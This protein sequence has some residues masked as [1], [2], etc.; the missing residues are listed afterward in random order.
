MSA[1]GLSRRDFIGGLGGIVVLFSLRGEAQG[2][3]E[4]RLPGSLQTNRRLDAWIRIDA[5]GIATVFTG[6]VELG[7][8]ILTALSQIVAE[9]LDLPLGRITLVSGDTERTPNEGTTS[10]SVSIENGGKALR[11]AGA[12]V[13]ALLVE[14]ASD[15]LGKPAADL[16]V[17]DGVIAGPDGRSVTYGELAASVNLQREATAGIA[18][19]SPRDHTLVGQSIG[20]VDIP[21]KVKGDAI[22]IQDMRL[23]GMLHGRIVRPPARGARLEG[24]EAS[25][26]RQAAGLV[27]IVRDGNFL[28]LVADDE[29][30]AVQLRAQL[31]ESAHWSEGDAL[32]KAQDIYDYLRSAPRQTAVVS[33]RGAPLPDGAVR[34]QA[35]YRKPYIAHASIGPSCAIA[36][37]EDQQLTVWTHSQNVFLLRLSLARVFELDIENVRCMHV[38]GSGCYG[39]NGADDVALDAALLARA[40][41]GRPVRLQWMRDDEFRWESYSPAMSM[42]IQGAV[43]EGRIVDWTYEVWSNT[44]S[45]RPMDRPGVNLQAAWDLESPVEPVAV[46]ISR[47]AAGTGDRNAVPLYDFPRQRVTHHLVEAMPLRTSALRTLGAH[48]NVWAIESFVDELAGMANADPVAFRLA[49]LEEVRG[50]AVIEA[51]RDKAG[52]QASTRR[53]G[54]VDGRMRGRGIGFAQYKNMQAYVAVVADL[55]VDARSGEIQLERMFAAADAGLA[56]NPDGLV[57]QIEGGMLQGAS[58]T[59][60]ESVQFD[61]RGIRSHDW[62]TYPILTMQEAPPI[63]V[64]LINRRDEEALGAGEASCGPA[65]AAIANAFANA[66]GARLRELPMTPERV[67]AALAAS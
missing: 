62:V 54:Q 13:R 41:P 48:A 25:G 57:N 18:P 4:R 32:P 2:V 39:H 61:E 44:H 14:L 24:Y 46:Q 12:E 67:R 50:R 11:Y 37:F 20:R 51:V 10:S 63:E 1:Q 21:P 47:G 65:A 52:W 64:Q 9:E 33:E 58:W 40:V 27:H 26:L 35:S 59:L 53:A 43:H 31:A 29:Y 6:K 8:G 34:L 66:T 45:T 28:G 16:K 17:R 30:R 22:F 23:P 19:K 55:S 60:K 56:I 7:Q 49:H 42:D 36:S 3:D 5:D 38:Q 15:R